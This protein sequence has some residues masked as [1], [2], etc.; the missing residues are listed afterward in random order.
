MAAVVL[1]VTQ[2]MVVVKTPLEMVAAVQVVVAIALHTGVRLVVVLVLL[3]KVF[4]VL[5]EQVVILVWVVQA[6]KTGLWAKTRG[7]P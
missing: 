2:V 6:G 3:V 1:A 7:S 4:L 5:L